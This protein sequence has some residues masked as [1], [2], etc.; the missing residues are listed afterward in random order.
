MEILTIKSLDDANQLAINQAANALCHGQVIIL[1][2]ATLYGL[3]CLYDNQAAL[4]QIYKLKQRKTSMP[5]IILFSKPKQ[6]E[7]LIQPPLPAVKKLM[8]QFWFSSH[9]QPLTMILNKKSG[10]PDYITA[11][12]PH[13]ALRYA[14]SRFLNQLISLTG[15]L[16]S[17]SA[18]LSGQKA[19]PDLPAK[20]PKQ[21]REKVSLIIESQQKLG[22]RESTIIDLTGT[23]PSLVREGALDYNAI[24][25]AIGKS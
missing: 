24:I 19:Y 17:T 20:I 1:P 12:S 22:G 10:L 14:G 16:T 3:S 21:I 4:N 8:D 15:P 23:H 25:K 13:I 6:L 11:S 18:T 7:A 5:L 9:P 2:T